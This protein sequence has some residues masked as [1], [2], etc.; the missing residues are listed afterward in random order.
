MA[1]GQLQLGDDS[2]QAQAP[3]QVPVAGDPNNKNQNTQAPTYASFGKVI[4]KG[5]VNAAIGDTVTATLDLNGNEGNRTD[6]PYAHQ[7]AFIKETQHNIPDVFWNWFSQQGRIYEAG[8]DDYTNGAVLDWL[9]TVGYPISEAYWV[10]TK[11]G[12]LERDVLVQLFERRVLTYTPDNPA[13]FKVEMG[14]VG[15]HYYSWRY[16]KF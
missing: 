1:T 12:G 10:H 11:V 7:A 9:S 2:F 16:G 14:N 3:C 15:Q 13:A 4:A 5:G 6:L 8:G